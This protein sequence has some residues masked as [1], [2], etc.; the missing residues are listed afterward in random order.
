MNQRTTRL[1]GNAMTERTGFVSRRV[2]TLAGPRPEN[3]AQAQDNRAQARAS[4]MQARNNRAQDSR[5]QAQEGRVG[6]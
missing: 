4:H 1:R 6:A 3:R 5:V 2:R